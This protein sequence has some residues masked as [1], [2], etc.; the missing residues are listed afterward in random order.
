MQDHHLKTAYRALSEHL[1]TRSRMAG[2]ASHLMGQLPNPDP[3]L[4]AL[5]RDI[6]AY[7]D[8]RADAHVGGCIRRRKA[9]VRSLQWG[10]ERGAASA[11][12]ASMCRR[13]LDA[14]DMGQLIGDILEAT[15]YGWQPLEVLWAHDGGAGLVLPRQVLA[16][17]PE[18]FTF[19]A[20]GQLRLRTRTS[21]IEGEAV[22][23][24]KFLLARQEASYAN[25]WGVGDLSLC[26]WPATFK[27]SGLKFWVQFTEKYGA[28]WVIGKHPRASDD[29]EAE[30]LLDCLEAMVQD[31]VAVIPDDSSIDIR[32]AAGRAASADAYERLLHYCRSEISIALLG[33]NQTTEASS[34]HASA[35]AGLEV[36]R[37]IRDGD[38]AIVESVVREL[39]A[40]IVH[41][42]EG[43]A[44]AVPIFAMWQQQAIDQI[45]AERD[46]KLTAMGVPLTREYFMRAYDLGEGDIAEQATPPQA[47]QPNLGLKRPLTPS[48]S[49]GEF[50]ENTPDAAAT[51]WDEQHLDALQDAADAH[52]AQWLE[53]LDGLTQSAP[54]LAALQDALLAEFGH[55]DTAA[56]AAVMAR[57]EAAA[58]LA[59]RWQVQ[60]ETHQEAAV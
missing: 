19:D 52:I 10:I 48:G 20:D 55:L 47:Q 57:A 41:I 22:P 6:S 32:E 50:A 7:R 18:W 21:P 8:I 45:R 17:P 42:N 51:E 9:A 30:R 15:L 40:H 38:A 4:K 11:R 44:A 12:A 33:Q 56:L 34:T 1:A 35:T 37:D 25:P 29:A 2:A 3:I 13:A 43:E 39:L 46:A 54:D 14:L 59:G 36:T 28:P 31:A 27:R 26:F 49:R 53:Q 23:P 16:K 58:H 60:Q 24:R 5:G